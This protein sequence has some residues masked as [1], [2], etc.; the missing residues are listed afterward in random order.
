MCMVLVMSAPRAALA[1]I[2][3]HRRHVSNFNRHVGATSALTVRIGASSRFQNHGQAHLAVDPGTAA[4]EYE[5][6]ARKEPRW[7]AA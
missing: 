5:V 3:H 4:T 1:P 6:S 2:L 7:V